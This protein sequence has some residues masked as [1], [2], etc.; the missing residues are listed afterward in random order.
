MHSEEPSANDNVAVKTVFFSF[1]GLINNSTVMLEEL[2][3]LGCESLCVL[4]LGERLWMAALGIVQNEAHSELQQAAL[5]KQQHSWPMLQN[6]VYTSV[7]LPTPWAHREQPPPPSPCSSTAATMFSRSLSALVS[8]LF[9]SLSLSHSHHRVIP[10]FLL[11]K[12]IV[13]RTL[14]HAFARWHPCTNAPR[15]LNIHPCVKITQS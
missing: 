15:A 2:C 8:I 4:L 1:N 13:K 3:Y 12:D 6:I 11:H 7:I 14:P 10:F 5:E 9:L